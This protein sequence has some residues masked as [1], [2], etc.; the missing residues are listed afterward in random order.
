[1]RGLMTAAPKCRSALTQNRH[2]A[3]VPSEE[4]RRF[5]VSFRSINTGIDKWTRYNV[6]T[7]YGERKAIALAAMAHAGAAPRTGILDVEV[8]IGKPPEA[9]STAS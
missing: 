7:W 2:Y 3:W 5:I 1:M 9:T 8:E 4:L 6:L